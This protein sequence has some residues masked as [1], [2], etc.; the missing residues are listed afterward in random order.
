MSRGTWSLHAPNGGASAWTLTPVDGAVDERGNPAAVD[1]VSCPSVSLCIAVDSAGNVLTS[2]NPTGGAGAWQLAHVAGA[3][4]L[5]GVSCPSVS[6]CVAVGTGAVVTSTDPTGGAVAWQL[7][8][9]DGT[10]DVLSV[11]CPSVSM[12]VATDLVGNVITSTDPTGGTSAW[13]LTHVDGR[14]GMDGISCPSV[15]LCVAVDYTGDVVTSTRPTGGA[16]AWKLLNVYF[17]NSLRGVSCASV[18]LCALV[19][20]LVVLTTTRPTYDASAWT[21]GPVDSLL[22]VSC[23]SVSLCVAV[24]STGNAVVGQAGPTPTEIKARLLSELVPHGRSAAIQALLRA[25][26]YTV[27]FTA[28]SAGEARIDWY[29]VPGRLARDSKPVLVA[30]GTRSFPTTGTRKL[31]I[32]ITAAGK[33]LLKHAKRITLTAQATFTPIGQPAVTA[34]KQFTLNR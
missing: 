2:T 1:G 23:A 34:T 28:L 18:S 7:A 24:D 25:R 8:H 31:T 14:S 9:I 26:G 30:T 33:G 6:L 16:A 21:L 32:D 11:S 29:L 20:D 5:L 19:G 13:T 10:D 12:C 3:G 22:G 4:S 27:S 17:T 15:S